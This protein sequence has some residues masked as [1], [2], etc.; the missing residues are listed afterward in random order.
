MHPLNLQ[1][2]YIISVH[3]YGNGTVMVHLYHTQLLKLV[4]AF[5]I[6]AVL[7]HDVATREKRLL[8]SELAFVLFT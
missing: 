3:T 7:I 4:C 5:A 1:M 6:G 8:G 2:T